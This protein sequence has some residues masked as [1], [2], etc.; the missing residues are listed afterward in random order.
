MVER[1]DERGSWM[2]RK[3]IVSRGSIKV[4]LDIS[5]ELQEL[6]KGIC[7]D[8]LSREPVATDMDKWTSEEVKMP[9][10]YNPACRGGVRV[11]TQFG[12]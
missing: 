9:C 4:G 11:P 7:Q 2:P 5:L 3:L 8:R 6:V 12:Y 10:I 1:H